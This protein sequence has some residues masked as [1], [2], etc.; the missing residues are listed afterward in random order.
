MTTG[1]CGEITARS[2]SRVMNSRVALIT[3]PACRGPMGAIWM[4][5]P[6]ISLPLRTSGASIGWHA[7]SVAREG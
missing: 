4:I 1:F 5:S 7:G 3:Q 6:S 2:P